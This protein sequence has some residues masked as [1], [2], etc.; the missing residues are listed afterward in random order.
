M[1]TRAGVVPKLAMKEMGS[2]YLSIV[3]YVLLENAPSRG[4]YQVRRPK[5]RRPLPRQTDR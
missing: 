5:N 1:K 3:L 4:D 2:R